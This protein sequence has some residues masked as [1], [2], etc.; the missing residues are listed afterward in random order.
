MYSLKEVID[1]LGL[2]PLTEEGGMWKKTYFSDITL[3]RGAMEQYPAERPLY[4]AI[5]Y[6]LTLK[7]CSCMHRLTTDEIWYHHSGPAVKLLMVYADGSSEVKLLGQDL[8][9]GERPQIMVP[10][11][12]WQ[13]AAIDAASCGEYRDSG[14]G[15]YTLMST[16][17]APEYLDC[18]YEVGSFDELKQYVDEDDLG[19]LEFLCTVRI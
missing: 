10:R 6:L 12:T 18:D 2:E 1:I 11:G 13:G 5:Y 8:L 4:G 17:M 15:I 7:S 9:R 3:P 19:L 14:D 16:S